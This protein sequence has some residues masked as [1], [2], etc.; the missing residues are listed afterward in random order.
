M[1]SCLPNVASAGFHKGLI[2]INPLYTKLWD[3]AETV[4]S[5]LPPQ[6]LSATRIE[7]YYSCAMEVKA[8]IGLYLR[9]TPQAYPGLPFSLHLCFTHAVQ[10]LLTLSTLDDPDFDQETVLRASELDISQVLKDVLEL[11]E[12]TAYEHDAAEGPQWPNLFRKSAETIRATISKWD[13]ALGRL[14]GTTHQGIGNRNP[15]GPDSGAIC[16]SDIGVAAF[17]YD[18]IITEESDWLAELFTF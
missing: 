16:S 15:S 7:S 8:I 6:P 13:A 12:R 18:P 4:R 17:S 10:I 14:R 11:T 2:T 9:S 1:S 5:H 3:G